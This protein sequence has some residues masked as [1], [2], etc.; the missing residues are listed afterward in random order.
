MLKDMQAISVILLIPHL[1]I[2]SPSNLQKPHGGHGWIETWDRHEPQFTNHNSAI[3]M[4]DLGVCADLC[5]SLI[6]GGGNKEENK[7]SQ[8]TEEGRRSFLALNHSFI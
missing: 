5:P 1:P 3:F 7:S 8:N 4:I 6:K 2:A